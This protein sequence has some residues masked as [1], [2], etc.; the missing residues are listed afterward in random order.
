MIRLENLRHT[1]FDGSAILQGISLS[2]A[3][4]ERVGIVGASG[5]GKSTLGYHLCGIHHRALPGTSS[6]RVLLGGR[7]CTE[8][9]CPGFAGVVMQNPEPQLFG[10]TVEEEIGLG[11]ENLGRSAGEVQEVV[12][13]MLD[14][15]GL[16]PWRAARTASLSLGLKQRLSIAAMLAME[17]RVLLLDEPTNYLDQPA[18]DGLFRLL[19]QLGA[20][21]G[22]TVL[23]VEHDLDRL[24]SWA[25][26]IIALDQG[27]VLADGPPAAVLPG[28]RQPLVRQR[29]V[30]RVVE[31]EAPLLVASRLVYGYER[32]RPVLD[33]VSLVVRP[34]EIVAL[35]GVNGSGK[36]TLLQVLKGLIR[37]QSGT[38]VLG[39]GAAPMD[40]VGLVLQN[41]DEQIFAHSVLEE[42]AYLLRNREVPAP[43]RDATALRTLGLL[44]LEGLAGR[45]PLTLSYGEKRR[46]A[47]ASTLVG[48][49]DIL[50]LD[51]PTVALDEVNLRVLAELFRG[52]AEQGRAI[53]FATHDHRFASAVATRRVLLE[54]GRIEADGPARREAA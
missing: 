39:N 7:D 12:R 41:P 46:L 17:P 44:G 42:C 43:E 47:L 28:L 34:G 15:L 2:I 40:G 5:S 37:P 31:G 3:R 54:A 35:Q 9:G 20:M 53:V 50:C 6:G 24:A 26:R 52:L 33:N 10:E 19:G 4:G 16:N 27:R 11:L 29:P 21:A 22:V 14:L 25:T 32:G 23:L 49:P 1:A 38:V 45:L 13:R 48:E 18:A 8:E 36:S 51:E 30:R